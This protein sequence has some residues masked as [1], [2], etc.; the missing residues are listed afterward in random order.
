MGVQ[1]PHAKGQNESLVVVFI[2]K[3]SQGSD[4]IVVTGT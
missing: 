4:V 1:I 3:I 2:I